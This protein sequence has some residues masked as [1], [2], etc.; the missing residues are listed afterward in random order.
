MVFQVAN[1]YDANKIQSICLTIM[2]LLGYSV[3]SKDKE[4]A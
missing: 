1:A 4:G 3:P 2:Q